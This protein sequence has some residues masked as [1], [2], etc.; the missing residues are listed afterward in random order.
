MGLGE[1]Y[2]LALGSAVIFLFLFQMIHITCSIYKDA[3][4]KLFLATDLYLHSLIP[5]HVPEEKPK[6]ESTA[7]KELLRS[8]ENT[9]NPHSLFA[10]YHTCQVRLVVKRWLTE[11][12]E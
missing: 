4:Y 6:I 5:I 7:D 2:S 11:I 1:V 10:M 3:I 9:Q 12:A 8:G